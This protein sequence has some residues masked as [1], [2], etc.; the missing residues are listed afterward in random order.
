M[1]IM[2]EATPVVEWALLGEWEQERI[3]S[4]IMEHLRRMPGDARAQFIAT[5]WPGELPAVDGDGM[6]VLEGVSR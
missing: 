4:R 2:L 3:V 6:P 5:Y 1:E